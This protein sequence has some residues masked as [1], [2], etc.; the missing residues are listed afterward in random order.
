MHSSGQAFLE[1]TNCNGT[2]FIEGMVTLR[3]YNG[4]TEVRMRLPENAM[5]LANLW[6]GYCR[7]IAREFEAKAGKRLDA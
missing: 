5:E 6:A 4:R 3:A 2:D 1:V 7:Q